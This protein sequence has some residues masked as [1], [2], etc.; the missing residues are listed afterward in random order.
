MNK[1]DKKKRKKEKKP[2]RHRQQY[3]GYHREEGGYREYQR[4]K[5]A[6]YM[7]MEDDLSLGGKQMMQYT[8]EISQNR[9][10]ETYLI[11]STT[12]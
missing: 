7:V 10:L 8:N 12:V 9:T 1:P 2:C 6:K 3:G 4:V 11:L 5:K